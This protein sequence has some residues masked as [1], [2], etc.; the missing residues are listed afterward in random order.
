MVLDIVVWGGVPEITAIFA[1]DDLE[2]HK[3]RQISK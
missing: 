1:C 3:N 2:G